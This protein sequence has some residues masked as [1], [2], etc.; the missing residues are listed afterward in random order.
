MS[1]TSKE[2]P[3][4]FT[5]EDWPQFLDWAEEYF[6]PASGRLDTFVKKGEAI[7]DFSRSQDRF[8]STRLFSIFLLVYASYKHYDMNPA[9]HM[10]SDYRVLRSFDGEMFECVFLKTKQEMVPTSTPV[11]SG[12]GVPLPGIDF[13]APGIMFP[14]PENFEHHE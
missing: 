5:S 14:S 8:V 6:S 3:V 1:E 4:D 9:E 12:I 2:M 10:N 11:S 7:I 13:P